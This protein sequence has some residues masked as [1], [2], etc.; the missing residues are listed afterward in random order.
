MPRVAYAGRMEELVVLYAVPIPVGHRVEVRWYA[1]VSSR[2][3]GGTAETPREHEP[4]IVD[5]DTGIE[6]A[7]D[8]AYAG[9]EG[10]RPDTPLELAPTITAAPGRVLRGVVRACRVIH[11]RRF[12]ELDVQTYLTIEPTR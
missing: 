3:F 5:L 2:L 8:H 7:S 10:K 1:Q 11:V 4:Q 9:G 12:S 6:Y